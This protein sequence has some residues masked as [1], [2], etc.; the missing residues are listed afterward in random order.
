VR[1]CAYA[2]VTAAAHAIGQVFLAV[3]A[4]SGEVAAIKRIRKS[5]LL[6]RH[7]VCVCV[8]G[9]GGKKGASV[10]QHSPGGVGAG[11]NGIHGA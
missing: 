8:W 10:L 11:R 5:V 3:K 4:D 7:K 2:Y 1:L 9:G 6:E